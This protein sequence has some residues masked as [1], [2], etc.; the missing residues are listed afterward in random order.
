MKSNRVTKKEDNSLDHRIERVCRSLSESNRSGL[1][2]QNRPNFKQH[3]PNR[4][5]LY[6]GIASGGISLE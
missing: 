5:P 3:F 4:F 1:L 2:C 6:C